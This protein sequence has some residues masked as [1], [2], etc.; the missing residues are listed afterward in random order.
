MRIERN[1]L[2]FALA[3]LSALSCTK[4]RVTLRSNPVEVKGVEAVV[5]SPE[6]TKAALDYKKVGREVFANGDAMCITLFKR[7]EQSLADY[8]YSTPVFYDYVNDGGSLYWTRHDGTAIP[9]KIFWSDPDSYHTIV[10]YSTPSAS[11]TANKWK[12]NGSSYYGALGD[13]TAASTPITF[14]SNA[15]IQ[16]EDILFSYNTAVEPNYNARL[17]FMHGLA[18]VRVVANIRAFA[19]GASVN[20]E[21]AV[22]TSMT[23]KNQPTLYKWNQ[24]LTE[25][26]RAVEL[27]SSDDSFV[28]SSWGASYDQKKDMAMWSTDPSGSGNKEEKTFTFYALAVPGTRDATFTFSVRYQNPIAAPGVMVTKNFTATLPDVLYKAGYMTTVNIAL[29]HENGDITLGLSYEDWLWADDQGNT[30]LQK[31][32]PYLTTTDMSTVTVAGDDER[33]FSTW[34][35]VDPVDGNVYDFFGNDGSALAPYTIKSADHLLSFMKELQGGRTFTGQHVLLDTDLTMQPKATFSTMTWASYGT[36]DGHFYAN[37][38]IS[39]LKGA[40]LFNALG[41][42][43]VIE[44]FDISSL[45][46]SGGTLAASNAGL[47]FGCHATGTSQ[48][49]GLVGTNEGSIVACTFEGSVLGST[50]GGL[51]QGGSGEIAVCGFAGTVAGA[52]CGVSGSSSSNVADCYY[53][54][55]LQSSGIT[56]VTGCT[57]L[58]TSQLKKAAM[59]TTL[60]TALSDWLA[61]N[62]TAA[63]SIVQTY[64]FEFTPMLYP[65]MTRQ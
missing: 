35:Y 4:E 9:E 64:S 63:A 49:G 56:P 65:T 42:N 5:G 6:S 15:S 11:F 7:T 18:L 39:S 13:P 10:A 62:P 25:A 2:L 51:A 57:G 43:A 30:V 17:V 54:S 31:H 55:T 27:G 21:N 28:Q 40:P 16:A 34:L 36:F 32:N 45:Q 26:W 12:Q 37:G 50:C 3:C 22:V 60:N 41:P 47:I 8:S 58:P 53:D 59:C 1:I 20:D 61:A 33:E 24:N 48:G 38:N 14:N 46:T 44:G 19:A 29:N 52:S 23:F